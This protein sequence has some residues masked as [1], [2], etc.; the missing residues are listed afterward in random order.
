VDKYINQI[1]FSG[2]EEFVNRYK[3]QAGN[4]LIGKFGLGFYSA[5]MVSSHVEVITQSFREGAKAVKWSCDGSPQYQIEDTSRD[6]R[7]TDI[8]LTIDQESTE[9]LEAARIQSLLSKYCR[10]LPVEIS[11]EDKVVNI[12]S[13][14]WTR[15]PNEVTDEDYRN[16]YSE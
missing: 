9:F 10:Y 14:A 15:K 5:F 12:T 16:F 2:A 1:A 8:I 3:D 11:F 13:P 6:S 4:Q 7:G